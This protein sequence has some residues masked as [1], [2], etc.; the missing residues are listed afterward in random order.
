MS[1][2]KAKIFAAIA[3]LADNDGVEITDSTHLLGDGSVLDSMKVVTLCILLED[4]AAEL[5]FDFDWTSDAA[6]SRSRSMFRTAGTLVAEFL[7]QQK[8]ST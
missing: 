7:N 8:A 3:E 4:F 6:M 5:D 1:D 2:L